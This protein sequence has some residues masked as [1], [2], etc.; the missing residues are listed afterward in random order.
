MPCWNIDENTHFPVGVDIQKP[1]QE[2][3]RNVHQ[4]L[5]PIKTILCLSHD[6]RNNPT[7]KITTYKMRLTMTMFANM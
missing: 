4:K 5:I 1:L 7:K 2:K 6:Y 3:K